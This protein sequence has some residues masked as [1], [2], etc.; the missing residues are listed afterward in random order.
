MPKPEIAKHYEDNPELLVRDGIAMTFLLI[1]LV[2]RS[3]NM[4]S[5]SERD[6]AVND[7]IDLANRFL[8]S[9]RQEGL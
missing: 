8:Y 5:V 1:G 2:R 4:A 3:I 7:S 6:R 9:S